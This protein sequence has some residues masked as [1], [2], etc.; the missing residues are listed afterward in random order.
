VGRQ[1]NLFILVLK[2]SFRTARFLSRSCI[3]TR[4]HTTRHLS[5]YTGTYSQL[6]TE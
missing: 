2:A 1:E 4:R 3:I 5:Q 6:R